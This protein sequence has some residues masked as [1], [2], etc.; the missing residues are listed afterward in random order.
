MFWKTGLNYVSCSPYRVPLARL[1][2]SQAVLE[3]KEKKTEEAKKVKNEV[4][5]ESISNIA[6]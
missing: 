5:E 3:E 6:N 1:A 4:E 2:A